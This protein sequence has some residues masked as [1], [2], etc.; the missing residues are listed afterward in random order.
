MATIQDIRGANTPQKNYEFEVELIGS[1][2]GGDLPILTQRVQNAVIPQKSVET[3]EINFKAGKT[4]HSGRDSSSHNNTITFWEDEEHNISNFFRAWL[5][6]INN[7]ETGAGTS[8]DQYEAQM[9][10]VQFASDG[11]TVTNSWILTKVFPI[12]MGD[13]TLAYDGSELQT[14]DITFWHDTCKPE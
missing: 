12:D 9:R 5:E 11:Q 14:V 2:A 13:V 4:G 3:I 1:V 7:S 6:A 8:R 10:V